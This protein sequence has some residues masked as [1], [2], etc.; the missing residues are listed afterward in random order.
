M[1]TVFLG[2]QERACPKDRNDLACLAVL[3][4]LSSFFPPLALHFTV[5]D[6]NLNRELL[7][8]WEEFVS[9]ELSSAYL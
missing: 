8:S 9:D 7:S 1:Q 3:P 6:R 5:A 4:F 2:K